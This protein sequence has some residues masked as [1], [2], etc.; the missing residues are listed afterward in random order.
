[1]GNAALTV[2]KKRILSC[3]IVFAVIYSLNCFV[4][5]PITSGLLN[6][7]IYSESFLPTLLGYFNEL[8]ELAAVSFCYAVMI[9]TVYRQEKGKCASVFIVFI[10]AT[11]YKYLANT[12]MAWILNGSVPKLWGWDIVNVFY[13]TVLE[14]LQLFIV[15]LFVKRIISG[16][17]DKR[18]I[19]ERALEK[20]G[21]DERVR[22]EKVE[23]VYP[24]KSVFDLNNCLLKSAFV[25]AVVMLVAKLLGALLS[26]IWLIVVYGAPEDG[27]TW[28]Y[29]AINYLSRIIM[30]VISY[31]I[32]YVSMTVLAKKQ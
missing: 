7:V 13:Y 16:Y 24:F 1:M 2:S 9:M 17:T 23:D 3:G 28:L 27:I 10:S 14:L 31:L 15:Y 25:C 4:I 8:T 5:S 18:H 32:V 26:D 12:A 19:M 11:L 22:A 21:E 30:G 29:M 20:V 6:D